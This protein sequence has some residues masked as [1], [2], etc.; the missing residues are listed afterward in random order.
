[1]LPLSRHTATRFVNNDV[2][3]SEEALTSVEPWVVPETAGR[4]IR[5]HYDDDI[6]QHHIIVNGYAYFTESSDVDIMVKAGVLLASEE[7]S[8]LRLSGSYHDIYV[9]GTVAG[10]Y[11]GITLGNFSSSSQTSTLGNRVVVAEGGTVLG[12]DT[13]IYAIGQVN[14]INSGEIVGMAHDHGVGITSQTWVDQA[15]NIVNHGLIAGSHTAILIQGNLNVSSVV[16]NF[17]TL[18]AG[19]L[20][21]GF[22]YRSTAC[23]DRLV[24]R[25]TIDGDVDLG[26]GDDFYHGRWGRVTEGVQ[27]DG[28]QG[29]DIFVPGLDEEIIVGGNGVDTLDFGNAGGAV[30]VFLSDGRGTKTAEGDAYYGIEVVQGSRHYNDTLEADLGGTTLFGRGGNDT[31]LG[32]RGNDR[33]IGGSGRDLLTGGVGHDAF[34]FRGVGEAEDRI[35]DFSSA[36]TGN[37]DRIQVSCSGFGAGLSLA[38]NLAD[39]LVF[40]ST[41]NFAQTAEH[42][43]IY[44][45]DDSRL[46]FDA[47][48]N[49]AEAA[50]L[51]A[52][53]QDGAQ[54]RNSDLVLI[55]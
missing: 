1:M 17:G 54:F 55:L 45:R 51:L 30:Q 44:E 6:L 37:N 28:G 48:G 46:W 52:D 42:R 10:D 38:D 26:S 34:E 3:S 15:I 13:A 11:H 36:T 53:L 29:N 21:S 39:R 27:I 8:G 49:G 32:E 35:S 33:L 16:R 2:P 40:R 24:N 19:E 41:D 25:G 7:T 50:I 5:D 14:V 43:F 20:G 22:A 12:N 23:T 47:D 4:S 9:A 31:L 18:S